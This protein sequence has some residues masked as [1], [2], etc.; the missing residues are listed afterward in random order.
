MSEEHLIILR[1]YVKYWLILDPINN[2]HYVKL[3]ANSIH[4][5]IMEKNVVT[6][7]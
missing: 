2:F 5:Q 3:E 4:D 6:L 7:S 1:A